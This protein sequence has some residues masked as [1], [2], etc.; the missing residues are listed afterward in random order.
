MT[1]EVLH[2]PPGG[3]SGNKNARSLVLLVRHEGHTVLLTG[4]MEGKGR[5]EVVNDAW[6]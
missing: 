1:F 6:N 5:T 4:D 2:P 3:P